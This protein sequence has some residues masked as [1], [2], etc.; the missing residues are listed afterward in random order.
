MAK[1]FKSITK[2]SEKDIVNYL[3]SVNIFRTSEF[4]RF[5]RAKEIEGDI[6]IKNYNDL[7]NL[8]KYLNKKGYDDFFKFITGSTSFVNCDH[9]VDAYLNKGS[10]GIKDFK[11]II[12]TAI[13]CSIEAVMMRMKTLGY[14]DREGCLEFEQRL[15]AW[16]LKE[17]FSF[18]NF[19]RLAFNLDIKYFNKSKL[20][21]F[22]LS[23]ADKTSMPY[24]MGCFDLLDKKINNDYLCTMQ[25]A[26]KDLDRE[27]WFDNS[28]RLALK[29]ACITLA[30]MGVP[31]FVLNKYSHKIRGKLYVAYIENN[32]LDENLSFA[33]SRDKTSSYAYE[34]AHSICDNISKYENRASILMPFIKCSN[35]DT[36]RSF[37]QNL[38]LKYMH[39]IMA[40]KIIRNDHSH[41]LN[42]RKRLDKK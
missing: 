27:R 11:K 28:D 12:S 20:K 39:I 41:I 17:N 14:T 9:T 18:F 26:L 37:A 10:K 8:C 36:I 3:I 38:D 13:E 6:S 31:Y 1:I 7:K 19:K 35:E 25:K 2:P 40:N 34:V 4:R 23:S 24:L 15:V 30:K 42:R 29:R 33:I 5:V 21:D 22:I 16:Y 32:M